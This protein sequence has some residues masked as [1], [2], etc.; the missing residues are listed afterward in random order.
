MLVT[1]AE[2][3]DSILIRFGQIIVVIRPPQDVDVFVDFK[4]HYYRSKTPVTHLRPPL[5]K[6]ENKDEIQDIPTRTGTR[7]SKV[8]DGDG[9]DGVAQV[10]IKMAKVFSIEGYSIAVYDSNEKMVQWIEWIPFC[11]SSAELV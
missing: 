11:N 5:T 10:V 4:I 1:V 6:H 3:G 2:V 9:E 8:K 7:P